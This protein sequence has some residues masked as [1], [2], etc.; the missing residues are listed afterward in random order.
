MTNA[1]L[2]GLTFPELLSYSGTETVR[3]HRW[4]AEHPAM[5]DRPFAEPPIASIRQLVRHIAFVEQRYAALIP[6]LPAP[7][8]S[9]ST[10]D[11]VDTLFAYVA[12][13]RRAFESSIARAAETGLD[14]TVEFMTLSAGLQRASARKMIAHALLHGMR[15]WAQL[16]TILRQEGERTNWS[17]DL[18]MSPALD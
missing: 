7:A 9:G 1:S 12:E 4:F 16:A 6:G 5:L 10:D 8:A 13:S 11:N 14:R 17:H 3:W 18:L 15:H 2:P